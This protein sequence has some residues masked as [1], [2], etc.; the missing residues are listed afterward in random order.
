[1]TEEMMGDVDMDSAD[2]EEVEEEKE[3]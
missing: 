1:M 2:F 3:D